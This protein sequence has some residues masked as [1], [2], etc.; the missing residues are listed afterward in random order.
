M[1]QKNELIHSFTR[2]K[3]LRLSSLLTVGASLIPLK[4]F[5]KEILQLKEINRAA[6]TM[7]SIVTFTAY[8]ED[9]RLCNNAIDE[10]IK[11]MKTIDK[12]MS[13]YDVNSHLSL[14][15]CHSI[16]Q[17]IAVD[18][19]IIE[20]LEHARKF[21]QL[22][23]GAFDVTIEPLM[24]LYGFRDDKS[25]HHFPTDKQIAQ[26]LDGVGFHNVS[27]SS[28]FERTTTNPKTQ[29]SKH[30]ISNRKPETENSKLGVVNLLH[31]NTRLDFGGIA[32][33]YAL[34]RAV[35]ILKRHGIESALINHSGDIF[36]LGTPPYE[37]AWEV[38]IVDP[39]N[40][41][42]IMTTVK[43]K[44]QA[45]S[46][47]GNYQN[48]IELNGKRIG[49]LLDPRTG[50]SASSILSG[51]VIANTA[52]EADAFSTGM[53]VMG[54]KEATQFLSQQKMHFIVIDSD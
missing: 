6:F 49:H 40:T 52:I 34:D 50:R 33:G 13:V 12:L 22:T 42:E 21:H 36:S 18:F 16:K 39:Q 5:S 11:E 54:K 2:R 28:N 15:N 1:V 31:E 38:G 3:F 32:V 14:V 19:R 23:G 37:D 10:A 4:I 41:E 51:T 47:S 8:H 24:E 35:N 29:N 46:T 20:V 7:G 45:L 27:F 53:F 17:E 9:E 30:L 44:N 48:F 26:V 25:L 43:I